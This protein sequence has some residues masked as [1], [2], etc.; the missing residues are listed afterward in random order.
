MEALQG[1]ALHDGQGTGWLQPKESDLKA[2]FCW[3]HCLAFANS[4]PVT[5]QPLGTSL[6][7]GTAHGRFLVWLGQW[8]PEP[9]PGGGRPAS[10]ALAED[11]GGGRVAVGFCR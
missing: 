4:L 9:S 2:M 1:G 8:E 6:G 11:D 10:L 5:L 7:A 3:G